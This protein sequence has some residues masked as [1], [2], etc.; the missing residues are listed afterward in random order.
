M[1]S[2]LLPSNRPFRAQFRFLARSITLSFSL[3]TNDSYIICASR[4]SLF[5]FCFAWNTLRAKMRARIAFRLL[6]V[7]FIA[8]QYPKRSSDSRSRRSASSRLTCF[9]Y[10]SFCSFVHRSRSG[11]TT[12]RLPL[13]SKHSTS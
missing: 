5:T 11:R 1:P 4:R 6:R 10:P 3:R 12:T 9:L 7:I 2:D 8:L 13:H